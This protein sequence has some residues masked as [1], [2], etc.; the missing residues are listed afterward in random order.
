MS[1]RAAGLFTLVNRPTL[2]IQR[3]WQCP[4]TQPPLT[5]LSY[6]S[7]HRQCRTAKTVSKRKVK[8]L[9]Q[10]PLVG[11]PLPALTPA[12]K[13]DLRKT[14]MIQD[15]RTNM[16]K[17]ANCVLITRVGNFYELYYEHAEH[18]APLLGLKCARRGKHGIAMA[19]WQYQYLERY[20]KILVQDLNKH[21]AICEEFPEYLDGQLQQPIPRRVT[22]VITPGTLIDENFVDQY[23]NNFLLAIHHVDMGKDSS[24]DL[25]MT[26][27]GSAEGTQHVGLAWIDVST[28]DFFVQTTTRAM[29]PSTLLR[30]GANEILVGRDVSQ[31]TREELALYLGVS[32]DRIVTGTATSVSEDMSAWQGRLDK[33]MSPEEIAALTQAEIAASNQILHYLESHLLNF[34][35]KLQAPQKHELDDSM[36]I[37]RSSVRGLELLKTARDGLGKGSLLH[38]LRRTVTKGGTRLLRER[39]A[40]PSINVNEIN[41]WLDLVTVFIKNQILHQ[42]LLIHLRSMHDVQR[43]LQKFVMNRADADDLLC[44]ANSVTQTKQILDLLARAVKDDVS[45][46]AI[47]RLTASVSMQGPQAMAEQIESSVDRQGVDYHPPNDL[48]GDMDSDHGDGLD[49]PGS[50]SLNGYESP[51]SDLYSKNTN[52]PETNGAAEQQESWI[53]QKNASRALQKLHQQL[54]DLLDEKHEL[55]TRL[56]EELQAPKLALKFDARNGHFCHAPRAKNVTDEVLKSVGARPI[57][58]T[59]STRQFIMPSW[60]E[61]G[62]RS[63]RV[64]FDVKIEEQRLFQELRQVVIENLVELRGNA[65]VMDELDV[66]TSFATLASEQNWTR[67]VLS[68]KS[69]HKIVG[70]R[71]PMVKLGVEEQGRSFVSNDLFLDERER[72]W[73]ITGPNMAGKSTFLRQNA[74]ITILAQMGSYVPAEFAELGIVDKIFSRIGAADDLFRNQ[75]TFM[76]EM[77]ETATILREATER[78]FVIM[79]EVGRGTTPEDGTA[80]AYASLH[81]LYHTNQCRTLFAT[82]FHAIADQSKDWPQLGQYCTDLYEDGSGAFSFIHKLRAGVNRKSH[83]L[84]VA[85]L[86][87][88]PRAALDTADEF[89]ALAKT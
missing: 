53:M 33:P 27:D 35:L 48:L 64:K 23:Q 19:G 18:Y 65:V 24:S 83:A 40:Y 77:L 49:L 36:V 39:L 52:G 11:V 74:V 59:K 70:G 20:L 67:P 50:E 87:G 72:C 31:T 26:K 82:H 61:L 17:F 5:W 2:H 32:Q 68:T 85:G 62:R 76:V 80:V 8:D 60:S 57:G 16:N 79:D 42:R 78:S 44:L 88:M 46:T 7:S 22:R 15:V 25:G 9:A 37:D 12:D 29:L 38:A 75:S 89:L 28:G 43:L 73:L 51:E 86:A 56:Q 13:E 4:W 1:G 58:T 71:H 45:R 6:T 81:H 3:T 69:I 41:H 63:E 84:K 21:V 55:Q 66:L 10:G 14:T 34:D 30:I 47:A 54:S